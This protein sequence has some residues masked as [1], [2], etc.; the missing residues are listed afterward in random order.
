MNSPI[1]EKS[2]TDRDKDALRHS[3]HVDL[4]W[5]QE[6]SLYNQLQM[7]DGHSILELGCG[8][9]RFAEHLIK[10][11]PNCIYQGLDT[12][13]SLIS[14]A[15]NLMTNA[16]YNNCAFSTGAIESFN[17]PDNSFDFVILRMILR[18]SPD[19]LLTLDAVKRVMKP[20]AVIVVYEN[21][22]SLIEKTSPECPILEELY[23]AYCAFMKDSSFH[24]TIGRELPSI[25]KK[26]NYTQLN[27]KLFCAHN[28]INGDSKLLSILD[29]ELSLKLVDAGYLRKNAISEIYRQWK[30]MLSDKSHSFYRILFASYG[31][32][33]IELTD[34]RTTENTDNIQDSVV[35]DKSFPSVNEIASILLNAIADDMSVS[36]D[37][38]DVKVPV[39]KSGIDSIAGVSLSMLIK[40]KWAIEYPV[41][42]I[43]S[44]RSLHQI[45]EELVSS[46]NSRNLNSASNVSDLNNSDS[47]EGI[48]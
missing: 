14:I 38:L 18:F 48:I 16:S 19:P 22:F 43:Y 15:N 45:A 34:N 3:A 30:I 21:D 9:G 13:D 27:L 6:L 39:N 35:T 17:L 40:D 31:R 42:K 12:N 10:S 4:F 25:L 8:S 26:A 32:K 41:T 44:D 1:S 36:I 11:F 29:P 37:E 2:I 33:N 5:E 23:S 28:A 7:K 24:P 46:L 20:G 47:D